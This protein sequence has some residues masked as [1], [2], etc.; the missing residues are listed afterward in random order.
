[1]A[2]QSP[3]QPESGAAPAAKR[4]QVIAA[5]EGPW[6]ER[7]QPDRQPQFRCIRRGRGTVIPEVR[8]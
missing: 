4:P 8:M 6:A 2:E 3:P 7:P 5:E 1:M